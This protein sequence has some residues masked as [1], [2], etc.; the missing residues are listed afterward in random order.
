MEEAVAETVAEAGG[1]GG[2]RVECA[3]GRRRRVRGGRQAVKGASDVSGQKG[4]DA[5]VGWQ[6]G[7]D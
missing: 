2:G 1:R 5:G 3:S 7:L 4:R 6:R